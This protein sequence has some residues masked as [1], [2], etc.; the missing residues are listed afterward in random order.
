MGVDIYLE[1]ENKTEK[2]NQAQITG[3]R[4]S[5]KTGYLRGAYFGGYSDVLNYLFDWMSWDE[6][7]P[8]D[9]QAFELR[10]NVIRKNRTRPNKNGWRQYRD[11]DHGF[12]QLHD[13]QNKD[14]DDETIKEYED[15]LTFGKTLIKNG[16][17]PKVYISY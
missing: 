14:I 4:T 2:E 5:G 16:K 12:N 9:P 8:F 17:N 3:F 15:F 1:W 13:R 10:L 7:T 6:V 11:A